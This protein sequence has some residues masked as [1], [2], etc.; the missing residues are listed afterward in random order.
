MFTTLV[1]TILWLSWCRI[2]LLKSTMI[3]TVTMRS[4]I[5]NSPQASLRHPTTC[6]GIFLGSN[7]TSYIIIP[8]SFSIK[9]ICSSIG[10]FTGIAFTCWILERTA[11]G[12]RSTIISF[13][14]PCSRCSTSRLSIISFY[15]SCQT[16]CRCG[17]TFT[18]YFC[19]K[20]CWSF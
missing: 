13:T 5:Y 4:R 12:S 10:S 16:S 1:I 6:R 14:V 2:I 7:K 19:W 3:R 15:R 8:F 9:I 17:S 18:I 20:S 11:I